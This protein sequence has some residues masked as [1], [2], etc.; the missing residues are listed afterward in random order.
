MSPASYYFHQSVVELTLN[1]EEY[2]EDENIFYYYK[3]PLLYDLDP[4]EGPVRVATLV[5][6]SGT[7]FENT[8]NQIK[9]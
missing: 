5:S 4:R 6:V 3:P 9:C 2:T 1:G 8:G 7:G